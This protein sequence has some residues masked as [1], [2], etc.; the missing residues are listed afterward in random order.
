MAGAAANVLPNP[1]PEEVKEERWHRFMQTQQ[2][3]SEERMKQKIGWEY[4]VLVDE[5]DEDG[6][7]A[8]SKA[9]AP[10]IDGCVFI[11]GETELEP[12][13]MVRVEITEAD[14]YDLWGQLV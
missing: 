12:G 8:R 3:I 4:E 1:V 9:D 10:D 13:D 5:V 11:N 7:I 2:A 6:A 14:H